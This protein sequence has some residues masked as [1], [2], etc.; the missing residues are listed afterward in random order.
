MEKRK[1]HFEHPNFGK[2]V[3]AS[4][5]FKNYFNC[6]NNNVSNCS[7]CFMYVNSIVQWL[8]AQI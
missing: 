4:T 5:S 8:R 6:F 2:I 7:E 1:S 3:C